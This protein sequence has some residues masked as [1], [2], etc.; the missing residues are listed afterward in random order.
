MSFSVPVVLVIFK[1][2]DSTLKV[3]DQIRK[4]RPRTL[5]LIGDGPRADRDGEAE[6]VAALREKAAAAVDWECDLITDFSDKNMGLKDRITTGMDAV[7]EKV[8][9]AIVL[10]DDCLPE[11]SFFPFCEEMLTRYEDDLRVM[12]VSGNNFLFGQMAVPHSYYFSRIFHCWGWATWRRAWQRHQPGMPKWPDLEKDGW[13]DEMIGDWAERKHWTAHF[14]ATLSGQIS[15]WAY[16]FTYSMWRNSGMSINPSVNLVTNIGLDA[17]AT[18][19]TVATIFDNVPSQPIAFPLKH[20]ETV[21]RNFSADSYY[22]HLAFQ[23]KRFY[24]W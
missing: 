16:E 10:E 11:D 8:D 15:S 20:P 13:L 21:M 5:F 4:V 7:F 1:R 17:H 22:A 6:E 2:E 24:E 3:L 23:P 12:A 18:N 19:T 9:R 14:N